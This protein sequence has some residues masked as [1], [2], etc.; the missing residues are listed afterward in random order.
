MLLAFTR[1]TD[2]KPFEVYNDLAEK[3]SHLEGR[4]K[5]WFPGN[6]FVYFF[7]DENFNLQYEKE[8][9]YGALF[10]AASIWAIFIACM[11]LFGLAAF[12]VAS[13]TKEI[14]IRKVLGAGTRGIAILLTKDFLLLVIVAI[15]VASPIAW[16]AMQRWLADFAYRVEIGWSIFAI[17]AG[18]A[19]L[20]ATLTVG[21]QSVRAAWANP[22]NSLRNE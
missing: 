15:V 10:S 8:R 4:Y 18:I 14:G 2:L 5:S 17:A 21:L 1:S 22:V 20:I 12:T 3:I 11:G 7:A 9:R 6:P 19:L 16:Y 13:R